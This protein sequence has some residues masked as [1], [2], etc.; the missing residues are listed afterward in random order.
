MFVI[1]GSQPFYRKTPYQNFGKAGYLYLYFWTHRLTVEGG[2]PGR[3]R[4]SGRKIPLRQHTVGQYWSLQCSL[5]TRAVLVGVHIA[6]G[7]RQ[8]P[9]KC[10]PGTTGQ[11]VVVEFAWLR[12]RLATSQSFKPSTLCMAHVMLSSVFL[13]FKPFVVYLRKCFSRNIIAGQRLP[14]FCPSCSRVLSVAVKECKSCC[15]PVQTRDPCVFLHSCY[16]LSIDNHSTLWYAFSA[17]FCRTY[18]IKMPF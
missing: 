6:T 16:H 13:F 4:G 10:A 14:V 2:N 9:T 7:P 11:D 17:S 5:S 12:I 8:S 15:T 3:G 18:L 1:P